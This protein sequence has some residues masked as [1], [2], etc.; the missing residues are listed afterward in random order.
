[1]SQLEPL[2]LIMPTVQLCTH[3]HLYIYICTLENTALDHF[4]CLYAQQ[5]AVGSKFLDN[6][7]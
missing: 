6:T 2:L 5:G 3:V 1:M 4:N 7:L